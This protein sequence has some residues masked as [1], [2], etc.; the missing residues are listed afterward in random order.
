MLPKAKILRLVFFFLQS[1][2]NFVCCSWIEYQFPQTASDYL[3]TVACLSVCYNKQIGMAMVF[4]YSFFV[5][6]YNH[7]GVV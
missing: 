2:A 7:V 6:S 5:V 3:V 1:W 4:T